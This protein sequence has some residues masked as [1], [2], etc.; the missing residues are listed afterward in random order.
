MDCFYCIIDSKLFKSQCKQTS[1]ELVAELPFEIGSSQNIFSAE[2]RLFIAQ[3]QV[4]YEYDQVT[5]D[6]QKCG[7]VP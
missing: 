1:V 2:G 6:V 3:S 5:N 7:K 4:L